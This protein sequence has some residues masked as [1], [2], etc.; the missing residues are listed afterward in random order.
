MGDIM[1]PIFIMGCQRSGTSALWKA[2]CQHPS[3]RQ[4]GPDDDGRPEST[5]KELWFLREFFLGRKTN[6][7]RPHAGT[8]IDEDFKRRFAG[9]VHQFCTEK[10]AGPS[11]RWISA[12][13]ADG[14]YVKEIL[15]LYSGIG[16]SVLYLIRHP[17]EVVWSSAH[18]P[19]VS[20][21]TR[22]EFLE[23]VPGAARWWRRFAEICV[24]IQRGEL[25]NRVMIVRQ[26][27]MILQSDVIARKVLQHVGED[28]HED[29]ATS[30]GNVLNSSFLMND[31]QSGHIIKSRQEIAKD[32]EFCRC[33]VSEVGDLMELL[34]Y[35]DLSGQYEPPGKYH[36]NACRKFAGI[37]IRLFSFRRILDLRSNR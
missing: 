34:A 15:E 4:I 18:A 27:D 17:Q 21:K 2:L 11:G 29:V 12:H 37:P 3:L 23:Y 22:R 1:G 35:K 13:P 25:G 10:Y 8:E 32:R 19:W 14:L 7:N 28:F 20:K 31:E 33:I 36:H 9:L 26:E 5:M 30:L 16:L 24:K 6:K